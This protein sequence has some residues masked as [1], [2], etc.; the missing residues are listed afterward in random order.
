MYRIQTTGLEVGPVVFCGKGVRDIVRTFMRY[1]TEGQSP[2]N[3]HAH[4]YQTPSP[5]K[6]LIFNFYIY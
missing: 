1:R 5:I 3:N 4:E 6:R 2:K